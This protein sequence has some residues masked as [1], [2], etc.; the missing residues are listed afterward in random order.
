MPPMN[1]ASTLVRG[2]IRG[3]LAHFTAKWEA[4]RER[5][6]LIVLAFQADQRGGATGGLQCADSMEDLRPQTPC[7]MH[8]GF[9]IPANLPMMRLLSLTE[10]FIHPFHEVCRS[11]SAFVGDV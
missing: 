7:W 2:D 3:L 5:H 9:R 11:L 1:G 8:D 4:G 6:A 10:G